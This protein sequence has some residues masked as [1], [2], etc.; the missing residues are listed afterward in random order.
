MNILKEEIKEL[1]LLLLFLSSWEE[2]EFG[3]KYRKSWKGYD[4]DVLNELADSGHIH[5]G[6]RSKTVYLSDIGIERAMELVKKYS[7][8]YEDNEK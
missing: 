7:I 3:A 5:D 4:F 1:T 6:R 2:N 8:N